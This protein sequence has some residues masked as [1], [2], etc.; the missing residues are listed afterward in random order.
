MS[1]L[2]ELAQ[3]YQVIRENQKYQQ[4]LKGLLLDTSNHL[5]CL[6]TLR[7]RAPKRKSDG[8]KKKRRKVQASSCYK[9]MSDI[10]KLEEG[11]PQP[12]VEFTKEQLDLLVASVERH[13]SRWKAVAS[14]MNEG[15]LD[16]YRNYNK[17]I[18][19]AKLFSNSLAPTCSPV[20]L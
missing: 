9:F 14:D 6:N 15:V 4:A 19:K 1:D 7:K 2:A 18:L 8:T 3:I 11:E 10:K 5:S 12:V 13:G 16:C 20:V 17:H